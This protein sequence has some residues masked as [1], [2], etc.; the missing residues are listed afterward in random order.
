MMKYFP[1]KLGQELLKKSD[2]CI[3]LASAGDLK[4]ARSLLNELRFVRHLFAA[5]LT[6]EERNLDLENIDETCKSLI[7]ELNRSLEILKNWLS[8]I[9]TSFP[10]DT[11]LATP[12]GLEILL[13]TN[14]P[15]TWSWEED[16]VLVSGTLPDQI[17]NALVTRGQKKII[18]LKSG[19]STDKIKYISEPSSAY[20]S[21][22]D[23]STDHIGRSIYLASSQTDR[24]PKDIIEE[25]SQITQD[26]R[27][28]QNTR[29][30]FART[31]VLQQVQ[32]LS[33][34]M[35]SRPVLA[36]A[37][38]IR[39]KHCI[40]VSPGP[41]LEKNIELLKT[42]DSSQLLI[43]VAQAAPALAKHSVQPDYIIVMDPIN[44]SA[45]L[46]NT[47]CSQ[48]RGLIIGDAC[49]TAFFAK[50]FPH[51]Y[52]F[53]N[54]KASFNVDKI[55]G[56]DMALPGGSVSV[57]AAMLS[58]FCGASHLT[59]VGQDLAIS[60][61]RY[62]G[63]YSDNKDIDTRCL[64]SV[65]GFFGTD[66]RT[67][68]DYAS[69]IREFERIAIHYGAKTTLNNATEGGAFIE[70]FNHITLADA[71]K[72]QGKQS[73]VFIPRPVGKSELTERVKSLS[74]AL[75]SEQDILSETHK[76]AIECSKLVKKIKNSDDPKLQVLK[77][78][79]KKLSLSADRSAA[80]Q[81]FCQLEVSSTLRQIKNS[82]TFADNKSLSA[83]LFETL[84]RASSLLHREIAT[85]L[86]NSET[87]LS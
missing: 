77:R 32:S 41:S 3:E 73:N 46:D 19:Q 57:G 16:L 66:V 81:I 78:K 26:F 29:S 8:S 70:G 87:L 33:Y 47:D 72:I 74:I 45:S 1:V 55:I 9:R 86:Q 85:Q 22:A 27:I 64:I 12:E 83:K 79:E 48:V 6:H 28:A 75:R 7:S 40:V 53:F 59:L 18:Y 76:L 17:I 37:A 23:W 80:L 31:W 21:L 62:Y 82:R 58:L 20:E 13:D 63:G 67:K 60:N 44:Y 49:H 56:S 10:I 43:A 50:K 54:I 69:F 4:E 14:L 68:P 39:D 51:I 61:G 30:H 65:P 34:V 5:E 36:L 42:R 15:L 35:R 25:I 24:P 84:I 52:T 38:E 11:L 2:A 71:L